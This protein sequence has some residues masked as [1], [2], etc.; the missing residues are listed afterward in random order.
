[1]AYGN[2]TN[3]PFGFRPSQYL[4]GSLYTGQQSPYLIAS[5]YAASIYQGDL[6]I[7]ANNGTINVAAAGG[8]IL[9]V[10]AGCK[11]IDA[12]GVAQYLKYWPANQVTMGAVNAEAFIIDDPDVLF[13]VQTS[14]STNVA[15]A[16]NT[17]S[18]STVQLYLNANLGL[19]GGGAAGPL[20]PANPA[21]GSTISGQ[22]AMYLDYNTLNTTATLQLKIVRFTPVPGNAS[23]VLFNNTLVLINNHVYKGGTGTLGV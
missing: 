17:V 2:A 19:A 23:A 9:G 16:I 13:D 18:I 22:S 15:S 14:N 4:N 1:M 6:V 11:F 10:F 20:A 7:Q 3:S 5:G 12:N 21:T 8:T